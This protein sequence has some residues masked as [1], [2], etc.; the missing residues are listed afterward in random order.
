MTA[1]LVHIGL[2][3]GALDVAAAIGD[4]TDDAPA[5]D[6]Q[7]AVWT[8]PPE[9]GLKTMGHK[10]MYLADVTIASQSFHLLI[11]TGSSMLVVPGD[12][13][14]SPGC[15]KHERLDTTKVKAAKRPVSVR[16]GM[17]A[18]HGNVDEGD[19][20]MSGLSESLQEVEFLQL[21]AQKRRSSLRGGNAVDLDSEDGGECSKMSFMVTDQESDDFSGEPFDGILGL[22]L[23]EAGVTGKEFSLLEQLAAA[24][25]ISST[26]FALHLDN[27]GSSQLYLG[28]M[29]QSQ[30]AESK[31][32]WVPLSPMSNGY[33]QFS[34]TDLTLNDEPQNYGGFEVAVDSGTSLLGADPD[35]Q[36]WMRERLQPKD[37]DSVNNLPKL[38]L[39]TQSGGTLT[40]LP[41]DYVDRRSGECSLSIMP[42]NFQSVNGQRVILGDSFLRRYTTIFDRKA[43]RLGFAVAAGDEMAHQL[44]P[45]MFP[46]PA[47]TAAPTTTEGPPPPMH[48]DYETFATATTTPELTADELAVKQRDEDMN[49]ALGKDDGI[50]ASAFEHAIQKEQSDSTGPKA[51]GQAAK[52]LELVRST[53][54]VQQASVGAAA[55]AGGGDYL[56]YLN[57]LQGEESRATAAGPRLSQEHAPRPRRS[58][59][60]G[61]RRV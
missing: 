34:V 33:W 3:L 1:L 29:D 38:G 16:F 19:V 25:K 57:L 58:I 56:S 61:L 8:P 40:L 44:L 7:P 11:D 48:A 41:S 12:G 54:A 20:C 53:P 5:A 26:A 22:G 2:L 39:R 13:C 4:V 31:V 10:T 6:G 35:T 46:A 17:G 49:A 15:A 23:E 51:A 32:L 28:D 9:Y 52:P 59:A 42:G 36:Q 60:I 50:D 30:F 45:S 55:D 18:I 37:C 27:S 24:G 43:Q 14:Q 47:T 21:S